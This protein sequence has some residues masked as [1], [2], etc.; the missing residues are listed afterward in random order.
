MHSCGSV[1]FTSACY[2]QKYRIVKVNCI[3]KTLLWNLINWL[4]CKYANGSQMQRECKW[5]RLHNVFQI[6]MLCEVVRAIVRVFMWAWIYGWKFCRIEIS[7]SIICILWQWWSWAFIQL[8]MNN[9]RC[10]KQNS[11]EIE[12]IINVLNEKAHKICSKYLKCV[13]IF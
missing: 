3:K 7:P 6:I 9:L 13:R 12:S 4:L 11:F 1:S 5:I 10:L 8:A 2:R